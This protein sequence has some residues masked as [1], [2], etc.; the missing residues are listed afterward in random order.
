[1]PAEYIKKYFFKE[2][3]FTLMEKNVHTKL[4]PPNH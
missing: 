2:I 3:S 1:M 4:I